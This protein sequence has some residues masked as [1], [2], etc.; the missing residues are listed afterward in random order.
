MVLVIAGAAS[1]N[2]AFPRT[3]LRDVNAVCGKP[4][5]AFVER[6]VMWYEI[7]D[8]LFLLKSAFCDRRGRG[9]IN[10]GK[11]RKVL[12]PYLYFETRGAC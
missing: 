2:Y 5:L 10:K 6:R 4:L 1:S 7:L 3:N 11:G 8:Y 9:E 12:L